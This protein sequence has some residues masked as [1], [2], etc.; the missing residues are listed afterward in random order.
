M[1]IKLYVVKKLL[2]FN[3]RQERHLLLINPGKYWSGSFAIYDSATEGAVRS[4]DESDQGTPR[5]E[6]HKRLFERYGPQAG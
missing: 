5:I 4:T 2:V 1:A 6:Y 3:S